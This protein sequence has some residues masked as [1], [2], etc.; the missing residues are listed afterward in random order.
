MESQ[1]LLAKPAPVVSEAKAKQAK[2]TK[3]SL[4][5]I[6]F[7]VFI[8]SAMYTIVLP[9]MPAY[10]TQVHAQAYVLGW[11]VSAF[12]AGQ[13]F[14]SP[15]LGMWFNARNALEPLL[16]SGALLVLGNVLYSIAWSKWWLVVSRVIIGM[17]AANVSVCRA[18]AA[19]VTPVDKRTGV[20]SL[21]A[22]A[23]GVGFVVGP[24]MGAALASVNYKIKVGGSLYPDGEYRINNATAPG[25]LS[26]VLCLINL[27]VLAL[28]FTDM[29]RVPLP[30]AKRG[31]EVYDTIDD[32]DTDVP[33]KI[34]NRPTTPTTPVPDP[35]PLH[36]IPARKSCAGVDKTLDLVAICLA[37]AIF[38]CIISCFGCFET[39]LSKLLKANY[40]WG[41]AKAGILFMSCGVISIFAFLTIKPLGNVIGDRLVLVVGLGIMIGTGLL[42]IAY[43]GGHV[44]LVQFLVANCIFSIGYPYSSAIIYALFSK[45]LGGTDQGTM[46]GL[47]TSCGSAARTLGPL[48]AGYGYYYGGT[49]TV[50]IVIGGLAALAL[51]LTLAGWSKLV[52]Y[53]VLLDRK[54]AKYRSSRRLVIQSA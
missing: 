13:F 41:T 33:A 45:I 50:Y 37:M 34:P 32:D 12:S 21:I 7:T 35:L 14:L 30:M 2:K 26:V 23:Q 5:I 22:A 38:F 19:A 48:A 46:M 24:A 16:F 11:L 39:T 54:L 18:Y 52:T 6:L 8:G 9:S 44:P 17:G 49:N 3:A 29:S 40:S 10:I 43:N 20:L 15:A 31:G 1:H 25:W 4:N 47:L 36:L 27:L 51:V 28:F 53:D 42:C